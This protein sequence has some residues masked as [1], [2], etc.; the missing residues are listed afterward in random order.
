MNPA[1]S[2]GFTR[3]RLMQ[4]LVGGVAGYAASQVLNATAWAQPQDDLT[5]LLAPIAQQYNLPALA[6]A[7]ARDGN[8][9][10]IGATGVRKRGSTELAQ[11]SDLF[12]IGSNTKSMTATLLGL[13]VED[14]T[15]TWQTTIADVFPDLLG[16]IL[17]DYHQVNLIALL[18]HRAG[19]EDLAIFHARAQQLQ[20]PLPDQRQ[21]MVKMVLAQSPAD[22]PETTYRYSN[23]T[24]V[25]A[26]AIA[27]RLTGRA[28]EDLMQ[29]RVFDPLALQTAGFGAPRSSETVDQPWG[30]R[31]LRADPVPPGPLADNPPVYGP[32]G[33]VHCSLADTIT[34]G[35]QHARGENGE[36]GLLL[37]PD[38][39]HALH[40]DWY[41]QEYALGWGLEHRDWAGGNALTHTGSN[42]YWFHDLW[43]APKRNTVLVSASNC[44]YGFEGCDAAVA[45]MI[46]QYLS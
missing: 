39:F 24:Y 41:G 5:E 19:I 30:H 12:H 27:E 21:T 28:W 10:G 26:G 7:F 38:T 9:V 20:G 25:V 1:T 18:S 43:I 11:T 14:G 44:G 23:W 32:A 13:L 3:R 40:R 15:L 31:G 29:D 42:T 22:P 36:S 37:T 35:N 34:Y 45:A 46:Q 16:T 17:P 6:A 8:L 2:L 4:A 33:T